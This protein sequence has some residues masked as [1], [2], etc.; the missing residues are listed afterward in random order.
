MAKL[1]VTYEGNE[2]KKELHFKNEIFTYTMKPTN[3]GKTSDA[4]AFDSQLEDKFGDE[5]EEMLEAA[6]QLDFGDEDEI[7]EALSILHEAERY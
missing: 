5:D 2:I 1:I 4:K 7:E 3:G 6:S